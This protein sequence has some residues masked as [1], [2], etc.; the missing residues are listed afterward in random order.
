MWLD[1]ITVGAILLWIIA[2]SGYIFSLNNELA[3]PLL[4]DY[5]VLSFLG[6]YMFALAFVA[7]TKTDLFKQDNIRYA[8]LS[9][10]DETLHSKPIDDSKEDVRSD[11]VISKLDKFLVEQETYLDHQLTIDKL[12][13]LTGIP[14]YKISKAINGE[15]N[16]NF[17]EY[18]N[19]FRVGH[20]IKK[21]RSGELRHMSLLGIALDSGFNSKA[22]F[23]RIFKKLTGKTPS[24]YAKDLPTN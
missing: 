1:W 12:S 23:N 10:A 7:F 22:S 20:V 15:K 14:K 21:M 13:S 9:N 17:F 11:D 19:A 24:Q 6:L 16:Q 2:L 4:T 18:I 8:R 5:L 3:K